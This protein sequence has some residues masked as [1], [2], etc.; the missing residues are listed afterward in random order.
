MPQKIYKSATN[1][2]EKKIEGGRV[3]QSAPCIRSQPSNCR[4]PG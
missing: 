4:R 3:E 1:G 2:L